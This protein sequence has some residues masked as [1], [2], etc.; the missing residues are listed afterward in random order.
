MEAD[1]AVAQGA[2][3]DADMSMDEEARQVEPVKLTL[4]V[5]AGEDTSAELAAL[6]SQI[7]ALEQRVSR[8]AQTWAEQR[9]E[10]LKEITAKDEAIWAM[11]QE[12]DASAAA[13]KGTAGDGAA[14]GTR[15]AKANAPVG[16]GKCGREHK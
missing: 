11:M 14:P 13:G 7:R 8:E 16:R 10:L 6:R 5:R 2:G 12:R 1:A 4:N 3:S 9:A 15:A